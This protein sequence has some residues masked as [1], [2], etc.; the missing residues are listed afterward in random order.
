MQSV[1]AN[2]KDDWVHFVSFKRPRTKL[3]ALFHILTAPNCERKHFFVL[4]AQS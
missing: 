1:D 2:G 4:V 3:I